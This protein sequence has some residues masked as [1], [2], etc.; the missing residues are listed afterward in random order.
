MAATMR[1]KKS[2]GFLPRWVVVLLAGSVGLAALIYLRVAIVD[3]YYSYRYADLDRDGVPNWRDQD[4]D[5]DGIDNFEDDDA[6]GN[7]TPNAEDIVAAARDMVGRLYD[8]AGGLGLTFG[9]RLGLMNE[10]D[11]PL[12]AMGKAGLFLEQLFNT[13]DE[14]AGTDED[15]AKY[16]DTET[17]MSRLVV[18]GFL[19]DAYNLPMPGDVVFFKDGYAGIV[20]DIDDQDVFKVVVAL[21]DKVSVVEV[22]SEH[23]QAEGHHVRCYGQLVP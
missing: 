6:N 11:V 13:P 4:M 14:G 22:T 21:A 16:R 19:Y 5:G 12:V 7:G 9:D 2:R 20:T 8:V 15:M 17:L 3:Q 10:A 18:Q 23:L 1:G